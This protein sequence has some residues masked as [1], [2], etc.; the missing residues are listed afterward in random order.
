MRER[1]ARLQL[2]ETFGQLWPFSRP[3]SPMADPKT[4]GKVFTPDP[5]ESEA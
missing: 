2:F 5:A 3:E 1:L 4:D